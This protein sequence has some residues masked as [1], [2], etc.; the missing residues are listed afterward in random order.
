MRRASK[1]EPSANTSASQATMLPTN[2]RG[3][4][5]KILNICQTYLIL[6]ANVPR[7]NQMFFHIDVHSSDSARR[8]EAGLKGRANQW[9]VTPHLQSSMALTTVQMASTLT[10]SA[11]STALNR[12]VISPPKEALPIRWGCCTVHASRSVHLFPLFSFLFLPYLLL[13]LLFI[14]FLVLA[15]KNQTISPFFFF[16]LLNL[17][18][19]CGNEQVLSDSPYAALTVRTLVSLCPFHS[20]SPLALLNL[21]PC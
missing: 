21:T 11:D 8:M 10:A 15:K 20:L 2:P 17:V 12:L 16:P 14:L 13:L 3:D 4:E 5:R 9:L 1:L 19:N 7:I 18:K 6:H